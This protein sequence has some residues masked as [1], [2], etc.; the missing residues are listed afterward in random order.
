MVIDV[1]TE[2]NF[3]G[4]K[5]FSNENF[6]LRSENFFA[7]FTIEF[8]PLQS[9]FRQFFLQ[10]LGGK[11]SLTNV[12]ALNI[13]IKKKKSLGNWSIVPFSGLA[14][15]YFRPPPKKVLIHCIAQDIK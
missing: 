12:S 10:L 5:E 7:L 4:G 6:A 9:T 15:Y 3:F 1:I 11:I 14:V 13:L 2:C 8:L